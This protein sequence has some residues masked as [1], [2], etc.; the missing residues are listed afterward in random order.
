MINLIFF[1]LFFLSKQTLT[2]QIYGNFGE[3][4][5]KLEQNETSNILIALLMLSHITEIAT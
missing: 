1:D 5:T 3:E 4:G 2:M